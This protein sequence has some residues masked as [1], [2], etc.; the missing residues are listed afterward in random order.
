MS[1][2]TIVMALIASL[3]GATADALAGGWT[4]QQGTGYYKIGFQLI[5]ADMFYEPNGN[6]TRITPLGDYTV[7]FYG[8]Y[9][10]T[11]WLTGIGYIPLYKRITLDRVVGRP[12]GIVYFPG[13]ETS[14]I[15]DMDLG[16]RLALIRDSPTVLA[17]ALMLGIPAGDGNQPNGLL[18]GDGEFN[19]LVALEAGHSFHP[20]PMFATAR[21]GF[22]NRT[23]G[24]SDEFHYGAQIG[25]T[26]DRRVTL[27]LH[28]RGVESLR[29]GDDSVIGGM[30]GL[31]ANNQQYLEYGLEGVYQLSDA[32]GVSLGVDTATR[33]RNVLSALKYSFGVSMS[34]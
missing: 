7:S 26:F 34:M 30:N 14:G 1:R 8:E 5:H 24:F 20:L 4:R 29:N 27:I 33:G 13:D 11:D 12:S 32:Y 10:I 9:G 16:V 3:V 2:I 21:I 31:Y 25:Y 6:K 23:R 15:A 28:A 17:F 22:N 19:Q 18:S